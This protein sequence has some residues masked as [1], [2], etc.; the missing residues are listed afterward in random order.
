M[1]HVPCVP[2]RTPWVN[3]GAWTSMI[4]SVHGALLDHLDSVP[5]VISEGEMKH[6]QPW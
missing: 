1:S 4:A 2:W 5:K 6:D 3:D